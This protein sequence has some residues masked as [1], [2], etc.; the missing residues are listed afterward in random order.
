MSS[1]NNFFT[2]I[3]IHSFPC[4]ACDCE[5][6]CV[7]RHFGLRSILHITDTSSTHGIAGYP[8]VELPRVLSSDIDNSNGISITFVQ[9]IENSAFGW[10]PKHVMLTYHIHQHVVHIRCRHR[11]TIQYHMTQLKGECPN[12]V[13]ERKA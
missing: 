13:E 4:Y 9:H 8:I 3:H 11:Y 1:A 5:C 12:F 6:A 7:C 10:N 2:P